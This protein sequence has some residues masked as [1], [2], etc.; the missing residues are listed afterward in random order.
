MLAM[1]V[2]LL[3]SIGLQDLDEDDAQSDAGSVFG[4][5]DWEEESVGDEAGLEGQRIS[6]SAGYWIKFHVRSS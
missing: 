2:S 5:G 4:D 3:K 6:L 1:L